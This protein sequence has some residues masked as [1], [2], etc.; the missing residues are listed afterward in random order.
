[1]P[2]FLPFQFPILGFAVGLFCRSFPGFLSLGFCLFVVLSVYLVCSFVF[3][4]F[5][6]VRVCVCLCVCVFFFFFRMMPFPALCELFSCASDALCSSSFVSYTGFLSL[7]FLFAL[8]LHPVVAFLLVVSNSFTGFCHWLLGF[9][10]WF[11]VCLLFCL[12]SLCVICVCSVPFV[13]VCVCVFVG[14]IP[15]S[16]LCVFVSLCGC[17]C[18]CL[19]VCLW[20]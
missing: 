10:F 11:F 15:V 4:L 3:C 20:V 13:F 12:F 19:C 8:L 16:V 14:L 18:A 2:S 6:C 9:C 7:V 5:V 17:A 1:M